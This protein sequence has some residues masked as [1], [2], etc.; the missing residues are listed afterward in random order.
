MLHSTSG[1]YLPSLTIKR[2]TFTGK[3]KRSK[4]EC[5]LVVN[6]QGK[7]CFE[8][9]CGEKSLKNSDKILLN[10]DSRISK[11]SGTE[12]IDNDD[13]DGRTAAYNED[14]TTLEGRKIDIRLLE[15]TALKRIKRLRNVRFEETNEFVDMGNM[16]GKDNSSKIVSSQREEPPRQNNIKNTNKNTKRVFEIPKVESYEI[17][18]PRE[19][20][21]SE[22]CRVFGGR[23]SAQNAVYKKNYVHESSTKG[24]T[25]F[26]NREANMVEF[27]S[28]SPVQ[29]KRLNPR[30]ELERIDRA[31]ELVERDNFMSDSINKNFTVDLPVIKKFVIRLPPIY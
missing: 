30:E 11:S 28:P 2:W 20:I 16:L 29:G 31:L 13:D 15:K 1:C 18:T 25:I 5:G 23:S 21:S 17:L 3:V 19:I 6:I 14:F 9:I 27:R 4:E 26:D 8:G 24:N 12:N 7:K 10:C 22:T